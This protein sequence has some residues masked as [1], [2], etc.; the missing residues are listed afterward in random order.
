MDKT[1]DNV[2]S[3]FTFVILR[4]IQEALRGEIVKSTVSPE[5]VRLARDIG[6]WEEADGQDL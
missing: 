1:H 3:S 6:E 2:I 4:S 5:L